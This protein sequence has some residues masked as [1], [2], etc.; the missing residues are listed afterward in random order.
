MDIETGNDPLN[1]DANG[2]DGAQIEAEPPSTA[3]KR[4]RPPKTDEQRE[5]EKSGEKATPIGG[6]SKRGRPKK[7]SA[8]FGDVDK[9]Q[10]AGQLSGLSAMMADKL[11]DARFA[12]QPI[13]S[14]MLSNAVV[15][16]CNEYGLSMEGKSGA[17][18]GL[19]IA[20]A[21]VAWPRMK[22]LRERAEFVKRQRE[23]AT[24]D[25]PAG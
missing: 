1:F 24:I 10:L 7:N 18:V 16:V 9:Q 25:I 22:L 17:L 14:M 21:I 15:N 12:F 13:E 8:R 19:I 5:A 4:G 11:G 2:N 3:K 6:A 23:G 20:S